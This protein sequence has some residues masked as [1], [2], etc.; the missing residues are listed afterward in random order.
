MKAVSP[1]RGPR[2]TTYKPSC[3]KNAGPC[4]W[5]GG[6]LCL[7]NLYDR[8]SRTAALHH[9]VRVLRPGGVALISDYKRT[10]EY[11]A[12]FRTLG[13]Q[14]EKKRGSLWATFPPLTIVVARKPL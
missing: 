13:L 12:E 6:Y 4:T 3:R 11:A 7:H 1:L 5:A 8:S 2:T 10:G 9:I 14:V